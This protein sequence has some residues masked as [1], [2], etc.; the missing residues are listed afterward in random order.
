[1]PPSLT[2]SDYLVRNHDGQDDQIAS[3]RLQF[4]EAVGSAVPA[5]L[6]RLRHP[7]YPDYRRLADINPEYWVMGSRFEDWQIDSDRD[8]QFT[9]VLMAWA[10]EFN[11]Q[12]EDWILE[13]ALQT[14]SYWR[15]FPRRR[16]S[17]DVSG[18]RQW[19]GVSLTISAEDRLFRFSDAGWDPTLV[20]AAGWRMNVKERFEAAVR[21]HVDQMRKLAVER[22]AI[23][24]VARFS[25]DHFEWLAMYQC[26]NLS[27]DS[28]LHRAQHVA[29]R[30]T[31]SKGIHSAATLAAIAVRPKSKL[32]RP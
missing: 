14:L 21:A 31:I 13:G 19:N 17:L 2:A 10:K 27:L 5:F 8:N 32:K 25:K 3:A 7:V 18:F 23:P 30:T 12:R 29:S 9:P 28:I 22:G 16:A 1:M 6:A 11:V 24:A 26:G 20:S 15:Q 4:I